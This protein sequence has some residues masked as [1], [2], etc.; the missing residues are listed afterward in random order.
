MNN[1]KII[2]TIGF[3]SALGTTL[4]AFIYIV[5][6]LIIG[7]D[8]PESK[9]DL[10]WILTP[11]MFLAFSFLIMM[12][13]VHYYASEDKRIWSQIGMLLAVAYFVFVNI[14]YFTILTV[15][16]PHTLNGDSASVE[17]LR[18]VPKSFMTGIDALGYTSMSLAT[19]FAA[20][21][22]FGTRLKNWIRIFF[23][24]NFLPDKKLLGSGY[25]CHSATSPI[26]RSCRTTTKRKLPECTKARSPERSA[27]SGSW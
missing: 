11:S 12:V 15:T 17:I 18:Y 4:F 13:S 27:M 25:A 22:F 14:V 3:W 9:N 20:P 21:V 2:L 5:P 16:M 10:F 6:Q 23:I 19:L 26:G 7:I 1:N 8:M 24:S